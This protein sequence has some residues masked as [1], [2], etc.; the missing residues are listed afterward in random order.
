MKLRGRKVVSLGV[1]LLCL[2]LIVSLSRDIFRLLKVGDR[3]EQAQQELKELEAKNDELKAKK[4]YYQSEAFVEEQA[5]NKLNLSREGETVVTLPE[6]L[7]ELIAH[8]GP[9]EPEEIPV[10]KQWVNLFF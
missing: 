6:N 1:F 7:E 8:Q 10:W 2:G 9:D 5:R 3:V 4:E